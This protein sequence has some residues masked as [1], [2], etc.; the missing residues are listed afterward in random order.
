MTPPPELVAAGYTVWGQID[1]LTERRRMW[2]VWFVGVVLL[3]IA[4]W[5]FS[6]S[7]ARVRPDVASTNLGLAGVITTEPAGTLR[8]QLPLIWPISAVLAVPIV[9]LLHEG[10][11][12]LCI[13]VFT[14]HAPRFGATW[15]GAYAALADGATLQRNRYL[16]VIVA[17]L[18]VLTLLSGLLLVV[19]PNWLVPGL[20]CCATFN[21]AGAIGDLVL[22][23]WIVRAP[24]HA[25][26]A[27][28]GLTTVVFHRDTG[29]REARSDWNGA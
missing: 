18:V 28:V 9:V 8:L 11:H 10:V 13:W 6:A 14:G 3:L 17:P 2:R 21:V 5:L 4:S 19:V 15:F 16:I 22:A 7:A 24:T 1:L 27:D 23:G 20:N 26:I 29:M 12:G 25:L